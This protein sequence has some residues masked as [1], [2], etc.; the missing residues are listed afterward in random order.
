MLHVP[1]AQAGTDSQSA[2]TE[3]AL[4]RERER[5][6]EPTEHASHSLAGELFW[7]LPNVPPSLAASLRPSVSLP[8]SLSLPRPP[9]MPPALPFASLARILR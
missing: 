3:Y 1:R 5:E 7:F 2:Q 6:R 8:S 4:E 9:L